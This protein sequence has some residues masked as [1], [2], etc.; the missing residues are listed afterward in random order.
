MKIK[1]CRQQLF[2]TMEEFI[3]FTGGNF[4]KLYINCKFW[5]NNVTF[6]DLEW[7]LLICK[8]LKYLKKIDIFILWCFL[9]ICI[10]FVHPFIHRLIQAKTSWVYTRGIP[11][12]GWLLFIKFCIIIMS[13]SITVIQYINIYIQ[14]GKCQ[15]S[16][17]NV[18]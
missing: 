3:Y 1:S 7:E 16:V 14:I 11:L 2:K 13:E 8:V 4:C 12:A 10:N 9:L 18:M 17:C 6:S 5:P 15:N